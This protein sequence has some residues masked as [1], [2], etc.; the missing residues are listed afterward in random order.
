MIHYNTLI[1]SCHEEVSNKMV[2]SSRKSGV[3]KFEF[4]SPNMQGKEITDDFTIER[5]K[6]EIHEYSKKGYQVMSLTSSNG[7]GRST[8]LTLDSTI[9]MSRGYKERH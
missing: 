7:R 1:I 9:V 3:I 5:L 2:Y 4:I 8:G 6:K